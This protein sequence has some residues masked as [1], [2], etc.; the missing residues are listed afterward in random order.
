MASASAP[1]AAAAPSRRLLRSP[2][3][4]HHPPPSGLP[5]APALLPCITS[6]SGSSCSHAGRLP[7]RIP[8]LPRSSAL[9][10]ATSASAAASALIRGASPCG[11]GGAPSNRVPANT[12]AA[13]AGGLRLLRHPRRR[14]AAAAATAAAAAATATAATATAAASPLVDLFAVVLGYACLVGSF[15]RSVPQI[16]LI[17][18]TGSA[19][20][21]SLTSNLVELAC[22]TVSVAYNIQQGYAFNTYGEV[23]AC[24][25]QDVIIVGL[26]F[27]HLRL[28][29]AVVAGAAAV[30]AA[31]CAWLFSPACPIEVLSGLQVSTIVIMA[32]GARLPQIWLN[33]RRGNAG[34][35]SP[36]TC[37]LNVAGCLVRVFTTAVLTRD[38]IIMGGCV[39]QLILNGILLY[40]SVATPG[41][42]A[43]HT[44]VTTTTPT[45]ATVAATVAATD[46]PTGGTGQARGQPAG[47]TTAVGANG[48]GTTGVRPSIPGGVG[49]SSDGGGGGGGAPPVPLPAAA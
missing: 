34:V 8:L 47:L 40:Q 44:T 31:A 18:K 46:P 11:G 7:Q 1:T 42:H 41:T 5:H 33:L 35:L 32:V 39:T 48:N 16:A 27:R 25:I 4:P 26:I 15:F 23:F 24:W 36:L 20:G 6:G 21:L 30:F 43:A 2:S 29:G 38:A 10:S 14:C 28:S 12:A 3:T 37:A 13:T 19:E 17:L 45:A 9:L 22:F 49:G